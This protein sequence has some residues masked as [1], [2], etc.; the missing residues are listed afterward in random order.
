[1]FGGSRSTKMPRPRRSTRHA[2]DAE[3]NHQFALHA[4][5][6]LV[7]LVHVVGFEPLDRPAV[8]PRDPAAASSVI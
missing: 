1:M 8:A 3:V 6:E 5:G 7:N 4:A 2:G